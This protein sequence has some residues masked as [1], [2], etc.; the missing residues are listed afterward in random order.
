MAEILRLSEIEGQYLYHTVLSKCFVI[1]S[2]VKVT[3]KGLPPSVPI[4]G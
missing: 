4:S 1:S 2:C 3:G